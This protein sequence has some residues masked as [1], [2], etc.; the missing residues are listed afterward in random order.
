MIGTFAS[1][2]GYQSGTLRLAGRAS[3]RCCLHC[4]LGCSKKSAAGA[5]SAPGRTPLRWQNSALHSFPIVIA[6]SLRLPG[7]SHRRTGS[8]YKV[9]R[10]AG[11]THKPLLF[12]LTTPSHHSTP[13]QM[14]FNLRLFFSSALALL[15]IVT[16]AAAEP[17]PEEKR[18]SES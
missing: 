13:T 15:A 4:C 8:E 17:I 16:I 1:D 5:V 11:A 12:S 14:F 2:P 3:D 7:H 10:A 9:D 18:Q 6:A